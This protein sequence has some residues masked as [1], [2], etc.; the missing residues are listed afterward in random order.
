MI[1]PL[2]CIIPNSHK[3]CFGSA[4]VNVDLDLGTKKNRDKLAYE[5]TKILKI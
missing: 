4:S 1:I 5:S 3:Q 2:I